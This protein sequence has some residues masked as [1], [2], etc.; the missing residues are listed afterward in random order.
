MDIKIFMKINTLSINLKSEFSA[1]ILETFTY[2]IC[3]IC[4]PRLKFQCA[5][6]SPASIRQM[7]KLGKPLNS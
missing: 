4:T 1:L 3:Y 7:L 6:T 5:F 2:F